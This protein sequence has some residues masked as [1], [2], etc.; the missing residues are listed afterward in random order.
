M[1]METVGGSYTLSVAG[2]G[3]FEIWDNWE[4]SWRLTTKS[5]GYY[6][7]TSPDLKNWDKDPLFHFTHDP[8]MDT[9]YYDYIPPVPDPVRFFKIVAE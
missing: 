8:V 9:W 6:L 5:E 1:W 2:D 7:E 4:G 3:V